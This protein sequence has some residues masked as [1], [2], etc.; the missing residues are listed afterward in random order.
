MYEYDLL[1]IDTVAKIGLMYIDG[2]KFEEV[3]LDKLTISCDDINYHH[4]YFNDLKIALLKLEKISPRLGITAILWQLRPDNRNIVVPVIAG[5][6]LPLEGW[7]IVPLNT[8][9]NKVFLTGR[10]GKKIR[11]GQ[12]NSIYYPLKNSSAEIVGVLELLYGRQP[13]GDI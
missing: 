10:S 6:A 11:P 2:D 8:E 4:E 9:M 13:G 3:L 5:R 7:N 12:D 1:D